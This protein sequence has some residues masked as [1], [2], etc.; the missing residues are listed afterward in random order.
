[1]NGVYKYLYTGLLNLRGIYFH[2]TSAHILSAIDT[3]V[4]PE[5]EVQLLLVF[6]K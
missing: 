1:M 2:V 3:K 4:A 6:P 5:T